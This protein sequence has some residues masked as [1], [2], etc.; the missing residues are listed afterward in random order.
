MAQSKVNRELDDVRGSLTNIDINVGYVTESKLKSNSPLHG[1][2]ENNLLPLQTINSDQN[3]EALVGVST[4]I[5]LHSPPKDNSTNTNLSQNST[6]MNWYFHHEQNHFSDYFD[7]PVLDGAVIGNSTSIIF[8][9]AK[10]DHKFLLIQRSNA[11][12]M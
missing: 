1:V 6:R 8:I 12:N 10:W 5:S 4:T 9:V 7:D 2:G 3:E 11:P